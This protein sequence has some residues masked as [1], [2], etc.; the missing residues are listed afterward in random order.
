[1]GSLHAQAYRRVRDHYPELPLEPQL[2]AA[3]DADPER[4]GDAQT[5]GFRQS[6][7]D[8]LEVIEHPDVEAVSI[9]TT[10]DAHL[11]LV[12]AAARAE[13]HIW[14]EKPVGRFP[15]ET[16]EAAR[17]A[18][19]AS[20]LST[21]G[22]NYR[23]V[24]LVAH[25]QRLR[26]EGAI[27]TVRNY[28]ARFFADYA[29][30]PARAF[31]WRFSED[32]AGLGVIGDQM[33]HVIDQAHQMVGPIAEVCALREIQIPERP[34]AAGATQFARLE[35]GEMRRVENDDY[36]AS[37]VRFENGATG[38]LEVSRTLVGRPCDFSFDLYG[39]DGAVSWSFQRMNE[40]D[41][42][43]AGNRDG[44]VGYKTIVAGPG[45]G[46]YSRFEPGAGNGMGYSQL[47]VC[48]AN[49]FLSSIADGRQGQPGLSEAETAG[50]VIDAMLRSSESGAWVRVE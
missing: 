48:E 11:S 20:I 49:S 29:S 47:K 45:H 18:R 21:V 7:T 4:A 22:F 10:N 33:S 32:T 43:V 24:P 2:I 3:A 5:L 39:S 34:S 25:A 13:K 16:R 12:E 35:G 8:P 19:E 23:Q 38:T 30:D 27:G 37:L 42:C 31:S 44:D 6:T 15:A 41:L 50:A 26:E 17:V 14:I 40:L 28:R 1:M 36:A 9:A 46:E